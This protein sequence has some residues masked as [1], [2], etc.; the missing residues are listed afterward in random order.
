MKSIHSIHR[1]RKSFLA[2]I[3]H[4]KHTL[5]DNDSPFPEHVSGQGC[6]VISLACFLLAL[7]LSQ[8]W[9]QEKREALA[10]RLAPSV[11]RFHVLAESDS[12]EDQQV[13]LEIRSLILDYLKDHLSIYADKEDTIA[14]LLE[15]KEEIEDLANRYLQKQGFD[16]QASLQLTNCYFPTRVY[17]R[18]VFPCGYY[19]AAR[20][21][22]GKG[23]GHNWW[24]VL[25]PQFCFVD[26]ACVAAPAESCQKLETEL[27]TKDFLALQDRR[28]DIQIR[29]FMFPWLTSTE[30]LSVET[31]EQKYQNENLPSRP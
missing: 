12:T 27:E 23:E 31:V 18:F 16:Y 28:P 20:I 10:E 17:D 5:T 11:L 9:V 19:D 1:F 8:G 22:L 14:C 30:N 29:L 24:C 7:L 25:Y 2:V 15:K 21:T 26:A 13:K 6:F 4:Q 3:S